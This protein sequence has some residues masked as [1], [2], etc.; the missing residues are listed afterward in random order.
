M[1]KHEYIKEK[2]IEEFIK[3]VIPKINNKSAFNHQYFNRRNKSYWNCHSIYNA[4]EKYEWRFRCT[5]PNNELRE[6]STYK[7]SEKTLNLIQKGLR[8]SLE[9][10]KSNEL[11]SYCLSTLD[12]GGVANYNYLKL[13]RMRD[14]IVPYFKN[15]INILDPKK[16]N[17]EDENLSGIIMN[18]GF[19]KIYSQ[20]VDDFVIYD[21][22]VGASLGLLIKQFLTEKEIENIPPV[23]KYSYGNARPTKDDQG[24]ANRRDPSNDIYKFP[25]LGNNN[26]K[27]T[28]NNIY[29]NWLLKELSEKSIFNREANPIRALESALFMIGYS[30]RQ[31]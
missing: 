16:A 28:K 27:H 12:W 17:I 21:S 6:G 22:R 20:L 30:V 4:F 23:L 2:V 18:S 9:E 7:E 14:N 19:T 13:G 31:E 25:V 10:E 8:K 15:A 26:L 29:A 11:L 24:K 3:W 5:L 1:N